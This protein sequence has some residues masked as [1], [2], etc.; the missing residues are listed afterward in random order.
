[1][2]KIFLGGTCAETDWRDEL[3]KSI[4]VKSFN[5]VV[6]DWT[7]DCIVI[8]EIEKA[9]KCNI[10]LYVI[11]S[12]MKGVYSI[13]E[14]IQ[15]SNTKGK[16]TIL[17]VMPDGFS[18]GQLRSLKAVCGLVRENGGIAYIDDEL[19]RTARVLNYCFKED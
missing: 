4:Q 15:S 16:V 19:Y 17:H 10:H 18:G 8:E 11:T 14:V 1:M 5:P 9:E 6:E 2:N 13:A 7:E 12:E 3:I